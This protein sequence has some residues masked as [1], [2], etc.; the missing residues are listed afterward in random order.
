LSFLKKIRRRGKNKF[1]SVTGFRKERKTQYCKEPQG[2]QNI[3]QSMTDTN[4]HNH[5]GVSINQ[6]INTKHAGTHGHK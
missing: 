2:P 3:T 6:N 5:F 1:L 4:E